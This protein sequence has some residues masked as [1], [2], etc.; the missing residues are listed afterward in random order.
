[1]H[2]D[3]QTLIVISHV[4]EAGDLVNVLVDR[5]GKISSADLDELRQVMQLFSFDILGLRA[6]KSGTND[7]RE[8]A[9]GKVVDM[10]L[11]LRAKARSNKDWATCDEIR[12]ALKEAGFEV[13]DTKDGCVW[14]L[15]K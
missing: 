15:N 1:M 10:V 7:D 13:K 8:A 14:K 9:Y 2:Y 5:K 3:L 11:Q 12:D 4:F 6:D